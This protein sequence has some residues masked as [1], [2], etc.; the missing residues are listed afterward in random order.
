[1]ASLAR[2]AKLPGDF[3]VLPGHMGMSTLSAE[4]KSNYY[5][6]EAMG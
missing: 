3:Q 6:Q 5:M 1:M 4:R 2:L